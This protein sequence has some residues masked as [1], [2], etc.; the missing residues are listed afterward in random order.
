M[1]SPVNLFN[2]DT[3][4]SVVGSVLIDP[5]SLRI[6]DLDGNH[7]YLEKNRII[8][9]IFKTLDQ[10]GIAIDFQTVTDELKRIGKYDYIGGANYLL[11]AISNTVSALNVESYASEI[12]DYAMRREILDIARRIASLALDTSRGIQEE[13]HKNVYELSNLFQTPK[14]AI[15]WSKFLAALYDDIEKRISEPKEIWGIATGY[16]KFDQVTGGI[17]PGEL[18]LFS[19]VPGIG[20]SLWVMQAAEQ[21]AAAGYAGAIYSFEMPASQTLRR[22]VSYKASIATRRLKSG[23]LEEKE[24]E[25][26]L[27][28]FEKL[29]VQPVYFSDA[30]QS[31]LSLRADLQRLKIRHGIQW[32]VFDYMFLASDGNGMTEVERTAMLSRQFKMTCRDLD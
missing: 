3:E 17:Q 20:K 15:H 27:Q 21:M 32:F 23:Q 22:M 28:A 4:R 26:L 19:G 10:K 2:A 9:E 12:K 14:G 16:K 1:G 7:F 29:S 18:M 5:S 24:H 30:G 25:K 8:W 13:L 6:V 11:E 31:T